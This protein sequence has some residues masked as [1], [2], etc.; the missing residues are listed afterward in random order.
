V[1]LVLL[2]AGVSAASVKTKV[3]PEL[4][5]KSD[6]QFFGPNNGSGADY[7][8]DRRP[9]AH[10]AWTYPFPDLQHE[11]V[12]DRDFVKDEN[13]DNGEWK[14][15]NDYDSAKRKLYKERREADD[16]KKKAEDK[17][18]EI[19]TAKEQYDAEV[20]DEQQ[21]EILTKKVEDKMRNVDD[22]QKQLEDAKNELKNFMDA[23]KGGKRP[24]SKEDITKREH[25]QRAALKS[26]EEE[27]QDVDNAQ[28]A[29]TD[30]QGRLQAMRGSKPE[31]TTTDEPAP[32]PET[33]EAPQ[34][35]RRSGAD[36]YASS[37]LSV[38]LTVLAL[39]CQ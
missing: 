5:P 21:V 2:S 39:T 12:F 17:R 27:Q 22:C 16:A 35:P 38:L 31:T 3:H 13:N 23:R 1:L 7:T 28:T 9:K 14:A 37:A 25:E 30:A 8:D 10:A 20:D 15:Q 29:L 32:E 24:I 11:E 34:K 26:A 4:D 33:T 19:L 36:R 18:V 6:K